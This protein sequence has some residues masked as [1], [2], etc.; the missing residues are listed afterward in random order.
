M[1]LPLGDGKWGCALPLALA[2]ASHGT[3]ADARTEVAVAGRGPC[4][5][6]CIDAVSTPQTSRLK[7]AAHMP[8]T[9]PCR[10]RLAVANIAGL[11]CRSIGYGE[12]QVAYAGCGQ[13]IMAGV[14]SLR[15]AARPGATLAGW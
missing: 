13:H 6:R 9:P 8:P 15:L 11:S 7:M 5:A 14:T 2:A 3:D 1:H 12:I 4:E 10:A